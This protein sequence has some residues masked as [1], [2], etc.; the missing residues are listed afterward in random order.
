[1]GRFRGQKWEGVYSEDYPFAT[2]TCKLIQVRA[3]PVCKDGVFDF[4]GLFATTCQDRVHAPPE[5]ANVSMN[6]HQPTLT[7]VALHHHHERKL[8]F[9][10][11][12]GCIRHGR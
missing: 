12:I 6:L 8:A 5:L 10:L 4:D 2:G 1:M 7:R 3:R 11:L 9:A